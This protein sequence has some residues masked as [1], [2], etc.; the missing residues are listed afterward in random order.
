MCDNCTENFKNDLAW[1]I[2]LH[3]V[4]VRDSLRNWGYICSSCCASCARA[5]TIDH[6][7][8]NCRRARPL[9]LFLLPL[10]SSLLGSP[11]VPNCT[12]V[13]LY[14]FPSAQ[15]KN[16]QLLLFFIKSIVYGIWKFRNQATFLNGK[17]DSN[18]IIRYIIRD[19]KNSILLDR[20][21][22]NVVTEVLSSGCAGPVSG[23]DGFLMDMDACLRAGP[24]SLEGEASECSHNNA[25]ILPFS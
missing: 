13:F 4:K 20:H 11:F 12:F 23:A 14:Q 3:A 1:L 21:D 16:F 19:V 10:L 5:E 9:W 24:F 18:A 8:L 6:C 7:F 15:Q 25:Q 17:E 22:N 2:T